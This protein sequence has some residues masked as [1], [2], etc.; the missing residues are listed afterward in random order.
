[1]VLGDSVKT[2]KGI[3]DKTAGMM[4]KLGINTI[5]DLLKYYPRTY[6]SYE[7]PVDVG[8]LQTGMRQS[9]RAVINSRVE[10]RKVRGLTISIVYA[11]DY[12]GTIKLMWFNCP[13]LRNFFHIGQEFVFS[14]EVS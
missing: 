14:G 4:A 13:F 10:V 6:I 11:K 1:M 9:V 7:D 5:S 3:G 12:S 8:G 2:I